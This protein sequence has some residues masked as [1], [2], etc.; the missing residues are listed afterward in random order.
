[1]AINIIG[2]DTLVFA[3]G[4]PDAA[5]RFLTDYG[6]IARSAAGSARRFE[7]ADGTGIEL[8]AEADPAFP[9]TLATS[10]RLRRTIYGV[11]D[12]ASLDAIVEELSKDRSPKR[13]AD[14]SVEVTDDLG[15]VL[16]FQITR[17][18]R[19]EAPAE[20]INAPG[21]APQ[22][23]ANTLGVEASFKPQ[24]RTLSH[25]ALFVPDVKVAET[26][27][28]R[29]GFRCT[30]RLGG[31]PFLRPAGTGEHHT[32]FLIGT[33][34]HMKGCEH[35]AFHVGG[36]GEVMRAGTRFEKMGYK[37]FWGP[38]RHIMGSNW[39]WYFTSPLGCNVEYDAD[40][41]L[42]DDGWLPRELPFHADNAQAFLLQSR[43][44]WVPGGPPP[45]K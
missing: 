17:R 39:F 44:T 30:D 34:P 35:L 2:P 43:E 23:P 7:A 11:A 21:A 5:A 33:P 37:T 4:E 41:D 13:H 12:A 29:L 26:F 32:L 8:V 28:A 24:P 14:G 31:G 15:F 40:M 25:C 16:G 10:N 38:G 9:N 18:R 19:I 20:S 3:V 27:Y 1:M 6:L 36:P 42:H 22:R 45:G